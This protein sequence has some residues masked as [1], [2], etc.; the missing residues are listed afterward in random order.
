MVRN[1]PVGVEPMTLDHK[2]LSSMK[3]HILLTCLFPF[4][5][6]DFVHQVS[7]ITLQRLYALFQILNYHTQSA[8]FH[9]GAG[10]ECL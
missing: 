6:I 2:E 1:G 8:D 5:G 4:K 10:A 3:C 7:L 9:I